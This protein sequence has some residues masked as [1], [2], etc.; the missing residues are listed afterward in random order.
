V[1]IVLD[2][3]EL[4]VKEST[5]ACTVLTGTVQGKIVTDATPTVAANIKDQVDRRSISLVSGRQ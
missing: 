3:A 4:M 2:A 5:K 1:L